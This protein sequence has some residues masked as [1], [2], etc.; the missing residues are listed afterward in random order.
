MWDNTYASNQLDIISKD[1]TLTGVLTKVYGLV[2]HHLDHIM[3]KSKE[4]RL[5]FC[6]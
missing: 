2:S 3:P 4:V 6:L 5:F 1:L